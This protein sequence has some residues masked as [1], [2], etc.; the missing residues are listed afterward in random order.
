MS[1]VKVPEGWESI[2]LEKVLEYEQ[3][4]KYL[5]S[6]ESY[7]N[8]YKTPVLT[9]GKTFVLGYTD[10]TNGIFNKDLPVLIFDDFTTASKYVDFP[11]KA[12]SSA[13][14][15]LKSK[16]ENVNIKLIFEIIQMINYIA[17][18]HKRYWISEYQLLEIKLPSVDEQKKIAQVL[19]TADKEIDLL[20]N[21]LQ[22]LKEQKKG[23]MQKLLTGEVRV[24]V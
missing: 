16:N 17:D 4:T 24:K 7:N 20:K 23:L 21:E 2:E 18:D 10:E 15:I 8:S 22:E 1:E 3:P 5:V 14:K 6:N 9:A 13:M 19:S 12:K 11:F